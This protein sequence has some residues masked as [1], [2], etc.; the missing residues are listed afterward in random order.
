ML[1]GRVA[2]HEIPGRAGN[3]PDDSAH[4]EGPAPA[5]ADDDLGDQNWSNACSH[6]DAGENQTIGDSPLRRWNPPRNELIGSRINDRFAGAKKKSHCR[7]QKY[8]EGDFC[9]NEGGQGGK[10]SP[11]QNS[12]REH[13]PRAEPVGEPSA[14][15][16]KKR[17]AHQKGA[18]YPAKLNMAQMIL[19]GDGAPRDGDIDAVEIGNRAQNK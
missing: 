15:R 12:R 11:P 16:L 3:Q 14:G 7:K 1:F 9:R 18:E 2:R 17:V 6:A 13:P 10:D 8:G 4:P 5:V 19:G